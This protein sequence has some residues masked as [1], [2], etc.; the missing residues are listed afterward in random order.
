MIKK[1]GTH[2]LFLNICLTFDMTC[3]CPENVYFPVI[4]HISPANAT[5]SLDFQLYSKR[6][7]LSTEFY[8]PFSKAGR[9]KP[10]IKVPQHEHTDSLTPTS[11]TSSSKEATKRKKVQIFRKVHTTS[12][13]ISS[14]SSR[15]SYFTFRR[16]SDL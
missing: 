6:V 16:F 13:A 4:Q 8:A 5:A 9:Y 14:A 1:H 3:K 7:R 10:H 15:S 2:L 11:P 12:L